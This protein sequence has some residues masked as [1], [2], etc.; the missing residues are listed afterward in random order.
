MKRRAFL[1]SAIAAFTAMIC[2]GFLKKKPANFSAR[3]L[4]QY[5]LAEIMEAR[6][7]A[8]KLGWLA[9]AMEE[10]NFSIAEEKMMLAAIY[11]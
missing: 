11:K 2:G 1:S 8:I 4:D 3:R 6:V 7:R 9:E 5:D 10:R